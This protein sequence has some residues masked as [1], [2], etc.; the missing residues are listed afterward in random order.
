ML[1]K[2]QSSGHHCDQVARSGYVSLICL[3]DSCQAGAPW[4]ASYD[5]STRACRFGTI[6]STSCHN[7]AIARRDMQRMMAVL[8][9]DCLDARFESWHEYTA[10]SSD[11]IGA[12]T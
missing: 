2:K 1:K 12:E 8:C 11:A 7:T 3:A 5:S 6:A 9:V 4:P 10:L